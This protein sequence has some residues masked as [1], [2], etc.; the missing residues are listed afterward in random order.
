MGRAPHGRRLSE[1]DG[2]EA[3]DGCH[4][5]SRRSAARAACPSG[6]RRARVRVGR[7]G[8]PVWGRALTRG[9]AS[10]DQ[11]FG[12]ASSVSAL[13]QRRSI[14]ALVRDARR[15]KGG[16]R[17]PDLPEDREGGRSAGSQHHVGGTRQLRRGARTIT[18][19]HLTLAEKRAARE[20]S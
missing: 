20:E 18:S 17:L 7:E 4:V 10:L 12:D 1:G 15:P 5:E 6:G 14:V 8:A 2:A 13:A 3:R 9:T 19:K 11:L 16:Q